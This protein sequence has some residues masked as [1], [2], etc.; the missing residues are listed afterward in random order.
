ALIQKEPG[1]LSLFPIDEKP[2]AILD[3]RV[4]DRGISEKIL[5][6]GFIAKTSGQRSFA[7]IINRRHFIPGLPQRVCNGR[8]IAMHARG[9]RLNHR[10]AIV[11]VDNK[12]WQ[13][14][15]FTVYDSKAIRLGRR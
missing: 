14:I 11:I 9:V 8:P 7:S 5:V 1:L 4:R 15:P 10:N 12:A 13:A 2:A 3:D 6:S